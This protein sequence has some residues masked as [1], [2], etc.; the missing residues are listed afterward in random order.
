[1]PDRKP[2]TIS[3]LPDRWDSLTRIS[4]ELGMTRSA[5]IELMVDYLDRGEKLTLG[6]FV[7]GVLND[8][9]TRRFL[10]RK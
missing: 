1:M 5:L 3:L 10:K 9:R 6:D 2:Y 8:I 7:D 4:E